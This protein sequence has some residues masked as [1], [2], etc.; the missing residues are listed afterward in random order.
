MEQQGFQPAGF[1]QTGFQQE[2][3]T[4]G[5]FQPVSDGISQTGFQPVSSTDPGFNSTGFQQEGSQNS[6]QGSFQI[7]AAKPEE[8]KKLPKQPK[9]RIIICC[10]GTWQ[11][12]AHGAQTIP[13]NVG[14]ISRSIASWYI[15]ENGLMAPQI[16]Y[17]DAGVGTAMNAVEA[18][19][20][21]KRHWF[22][23]VSA[24]NK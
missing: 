22:K 1:S 11:S 13:S 6:A 8:K 16:V 21:G 17:Y 7:P 2:G 23:R 15:D 12:S 20:N 4:Q 10:D 24:P 3:F 14:K 18:F 9:K 19:W 5:G